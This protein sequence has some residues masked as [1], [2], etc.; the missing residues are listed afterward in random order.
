MEKKRNIKV[1]SYYLPQFHEIEENNIW[2]GKGFTEWTHVKA[3]NQLNRKHLAPVVPKDNNYYNLLNPETVRWQI[4]LAQKYK[5]DVFA[6]YHY[7]FEGK[8]I[9][10]KPLE[11]YLNLD[12]L[13]HEYMIVWAN[14]S[15]FRGKNGKKELLIEQTYGGEKD[16][17]LHF[18]YLLQFFNDKRYLKIANKP[19]IQIYDPCSVPDFDKMID[20]WDSL[21]KLNGYSGIYIIENITNIT[22]DTSYLHGQA[23]VLRQPN[24]SIKYYRSVFRGYFFQKLFY[25][26]SKKLNLHFFEQLDYKTIAKIE[27]NIDKSAFPIGNNKKV[28]YCISSGWDNSPR[29]GYRGKAFKNFRAVYFKNAFEKLY[30][31]SIQEGNDL[32]FVNAWNEWAEGMVLEPTEQFGYSLLESIRD[33]VN[34]TQ[35]MDK[36]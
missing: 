34:E 21:A 14:H 7:W 20:F 3:A 25:E 19:V 15:W 5:V 17:R 6:Y 35:I 9:M 11:N 36:E 16:W 18:E 27:K 1:V 32:I 8:L 12:N 23:T 22:D 26:S 24:L 29:H 4:D 13:D 31:R 10:E 30:Y 28:F 33:T 2:W